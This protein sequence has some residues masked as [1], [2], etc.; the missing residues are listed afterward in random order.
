MIPFVTIVMKSSNVFIN[1]IPLLST[2]T[3]IHSPS[4]VRIPLVIPSLAP[5]VTPSLASGPHLRLVHLK[6][7]TVVKWP[8]GAWQRVIA[9]VGI[10]V[11]PTL[12]RCLV[13]LLEMVRTM[14]SWTLWLKQ[15]LL[16]SRK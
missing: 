3:T 1:I 2:L 16:Q 8:L 11:C 14:L 6:V 10:R 12:S 15:S 9:S 7:R 5:L 13:L 4:H